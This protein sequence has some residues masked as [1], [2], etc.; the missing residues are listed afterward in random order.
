MRVRVLVG[1]LLFLLIVSGSAAWA[2]SPEQAPSSSYNLFQS[3]PPAVRQFS[4]PTGEVQK[5]TLPRGGKLQ[6]FPL[7]G[8]TV[9]VPSS[10]SDTDCYTMRTY[11]VKREGNSDS[12]R[13]AGYQ[14][15]MPSSRVR[16][17]NVP[18]QQ[19]GDS[20]EVPAQR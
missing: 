10:P 9:V 3:G 19:N 14:E 20:V 2:D 15:C 1:V 11:T 5:F 7:P 17:K 4:M 8:R 18:A 16:M 13:P 12:T 6:I